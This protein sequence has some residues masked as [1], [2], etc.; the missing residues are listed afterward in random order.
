MT[1]KLSIKTKRKSVDVP[2]SG[3]DP[4]I[5]ELVKELSDLREAAPGYVGTYSEVSTDGLTR[6][7]TFSW[8]S[9]E[10]ALAFRQANLELIEKIDG[11]KK[12]YRKAKGMTSRR[13][14]SST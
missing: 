6:T 10:D 5:A 8:Q 7:A 11:L 3:I 12:A 14:V 1:H 9:K 2:F 13:A 4:E